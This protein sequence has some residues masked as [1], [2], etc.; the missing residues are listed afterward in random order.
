MPKVKQRTYCYDDIQTIPCPHSRI[1]CLQGQQDD[2]HCCSCQIVLE[3]K[4]C[5]S[6]LTAP[7]GNVCL[8]MFEKHTFTY[9][10]C[11]SRVEILAV[12]TSYTMHG[13]TL[14]F[15]TYCLSELC[16][17][18]NELTR[19]AL[20]LSWGCHRPWEYLLCRPPSV[21]RIFRRAVQAS[22]KPDPTQ[23]SA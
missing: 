1:M 11:E 7:R 18:K 6:V 13:L 4:L 23:N 22:A 8:R 12:C 2:E 17:G 15:M 19:T 20:L 3:G 14:C 16:T 10:A 9:V 5:P 21:R